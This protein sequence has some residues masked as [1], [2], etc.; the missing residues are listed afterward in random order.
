MKH[1]SW[2]ADEQ[3]QNVVKTGLPVAGV[4]MRVA[5]PDDLDKE[6]VLG[7]RLDMRLD[8]SGMARHE[9][10]HVRHG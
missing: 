5:D 3:F 7:M 4:Q 2:S 10:R 6:V 8:M 9:A 1:L